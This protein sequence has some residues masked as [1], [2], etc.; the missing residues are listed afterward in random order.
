MWPIILIQALASQV[1]LR[2]Q[3]RLA[4]T[5]L[6][7]LPIPV[8]CVKKPVRYSTPETISALRNSRTGRLR[9]NGNPF[10]A[11]SRQWVAANIRWSEAHA[12]NVLRSLELH[13]FPLIGNALVTDL[14][15]ADL[16]ISLRAAEKRLS[17][18]DCTDMPSLRF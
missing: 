4:L 3:G 5:R 6:S 16:L 14:K 9:K 8:N 7:H 1:P 18:N 13:V 11:V 2:R 17:G 12:A 15:T 10:E